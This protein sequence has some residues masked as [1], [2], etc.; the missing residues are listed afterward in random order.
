MRGQPGL[1]DLGHSCSWSPRSASLTSCRPTAPARKQQR[2]DHDN[3]RSCWIE[4]TDADR[5]FVKRGAPSRLQQRAIAGES[6]R[7]ADDVH[8]QHLP[9]PDAP[10]AE[11]LG[12]STTMGGTLVNQ[13][14]LVS[15]NMSRLIKACD[16]GCGSGTA[17]SIVVST[18]AWPGHH[19][20]RNRPRRGAGAWRA[21][22]SWAVC[23]QLDVLG[24]LCNTHCAARYGPAAPR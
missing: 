6:R 20:Y 3:S 10:G 16:V 9:P 19:S 5:L 12:C 13:A 23:L 1:C 18:T 4:P 22:H 17:R 21:H 2:P 7:C 11:A 24:A 8:S 15:P 14:R